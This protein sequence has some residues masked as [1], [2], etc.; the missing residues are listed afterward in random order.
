MFPKVPRQGTKSPA[1][2]MLF[3][4]MDEELP[5]NYQVY[6]SVAWQN[7]D[8]RGAIRDG[9]ADFVVVNPNGEILVLEVKGGRHISYNPD[10]DQWWSNGNEIKDPFI[11]SR[12]AK[13]SLLR[14]LKEYFGELEYFTIGNAVAF[15]EV[16]INAD[17]RLD[18][19]R[20]I[21]IDANDLKNLDRWF[22]RYFNY[23]SPDTKN[24]RHP[25]S[26]QRVEDIKR[27]LTPPIEFS[28]PVTEYFAE[29]KQIIKELTVE[30]LTILDHLKRQRQVAI[31]GCAGS[32]KTLVAVEKAIRLN[33]E[34]FYVLFL[35]HNAY[36][37][38]YVRELVVGYEIIV[39]D[40]ATFVNYLI[41]NHL[42]PDFSFKNIIEQ[43]FLAWSQYADLSQ[44]D[45]AIAL[46]QLLI[47]K[48]RFD[49]VIVDEGQDF[50][51][52]WWPI[53]EGCLQ[54]PKHGIF[55]I[56]FDD[57]QAIYPTSSFTNQFPIPVSEYY[58]SR[59]CRNAGNI[60]DI[61][62][63]LHPDSPE[64]H[65]KL[66]ERG[67]VKHYYFSTPDG[68]Y[69]STDE[70]F[71]RMEEILRE[72]EKYISNLMKIVVMVESIKG[73]ELNGLVFDTPK[74]RKRR[75]IGNLKWQESVFNL[76]N[77]YGFLGYGLS[78]SLSPTTKDIEQINSFCKN[79]LFKRY[80]K[81]CSRDFLNSMT[82]HI[83]RQG[84]L[85]LNW[86][87][88]TVFKLSG[89]E[90]LSFFAE[91]NWATKLPSNHKRYRLTAIEDLSKC[92]DFINIQLVD[93]P[94]FKGLEAD[95]V[96]FVWEE[97]IPREPELF[98]SN[99]YV[100]LS[101]AKYLLF[102]VSPF[103]IKEKIVELNKSW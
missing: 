66:S 11:Q 49:A 38:Q 35:C 78:D 7:K 58:L 64:T 96:I 18:A 84:K 92:P 53:V 42:N 77:P 63:E 95:G 56:F 81:S 20:E 59:N 39:V 10:L 9:E 43:D 34:K 23:L 69:T 102:I 82:W 2:K 25:L 67:I 86:N 74:I 13:Y 26:N 15:P 22:D 14:K 24:R 51:E 73:S 76:L 91:N 6:H 101:R 61:V 50:N 90:I 62:K 16:E 70:F 98:R 60:F 41:T 37:A 5:P 85:R 32:G 94:S 29:I 93:I 57:N 40:F 79:R 65:E 52:N 80:G 27:L 36:L 83:D 75:T 54:N 72:A 4:K 89:L 31:Y 8:Y 103:D 68:S 28:S 19:P 17:I 30:Q 1:E 97:L 99:L 48:D 3:E 88:N 71:F 47:S 100:S 44:T 45:L 21:V 12:E 33:S 87:K 55:Y 46:D